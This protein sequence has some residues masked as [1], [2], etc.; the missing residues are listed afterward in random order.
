[1]TAQQ[2]RD[3]TALPFLTSGINPST[4][5]QSNNWKD[6]HETPPHSSPQIQQ[7][8][9][10]TNFTQQHIPTPAASASSIPPHMRHPQPPPDISFS[11]SNPT[12]QPPH[13][14]SPMT[15]I[16][17]LPKIPCFHVPANHPMFIEYFNKNSAPKTPS[18]ESRPPPHQSTYHCQEQLYNAVE[19]N[20]TRRQGEED[21]KITATTI[22]AAVNQIR[23]RDR[24][25]ADGSNFRKW[26]RRVQEL[27]HQFLYDPDFFT[28]RCVNTHSEKVGQAILISS[29]DPS[30]EDEISLFTTCVDIFSNIST[31]FS[32]ICRSTQIALFMKL[33][34]LDPESFPTVSAFATKLRDTI[35]EFKSLNL[36][37]N[38][39][40]IIGLVMQMNLRD[41]PVKED[42]VRKVEQNIAL[43]HYTRPLVLMISSRS[44]TSVNSKFLFPIQKFQLLLSFRPRLPHTILLLQYQLLKPLNFM[45]PLSRSMT[46][47][48][49]VATV[50]FAANQATDSPDSPNLYNQSSGYQPYCPIVV[51]PNFLP[52][53]APYPYQYNPYSPLTNVQPSSTPRQQITFPK[54]QNPNQQQYELYK[55]NYVKR[56]NPVAALNVDV[57][58][59]E[60]EIAEL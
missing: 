46:T 8:P 30:L 59:V 29:V 11:S 5:K 24:L 43:T 53:G 23:D 7:L 57:G 6:K 37:I 26:N 34:Q 45:I 58:T 16:N 9:P 1:M 14:I 25:L 38:N 32:S 10:Q 27:A 2:Q 50:T 55:P 21:R 51:S 18:P 4:S 13:N 48:L 17:D 28:K 49:K 40:S 56:P 20:Q 42:F 15:N 41:G 60:D 31:R 44:S 33:L 36:T 52:Y 19:E 3:G 54:S 47:L 22:N 35:A 12:I 39:D